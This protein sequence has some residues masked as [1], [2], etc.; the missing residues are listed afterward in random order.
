[1]PLYWTGSPIGN[2]T[3]DQQYPLA[4]QGF[5][6]TLLLTPYINPGYAATIFIR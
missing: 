3:T 1:V 5:A 6:P 4:H 2:P